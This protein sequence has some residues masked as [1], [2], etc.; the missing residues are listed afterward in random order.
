MSSEIDILREILAATF[1][2][3]TI[4]DDI[5][6]LGIGDLVEWDSLGNFNFLL[7]VE[8]KYD[9]RFDIEQMADIKSVQD[10]ISYLANRR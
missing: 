9:L 5:S 4:P 3:S 10:V 8:E 6:Q 1:S 7:A 2:N